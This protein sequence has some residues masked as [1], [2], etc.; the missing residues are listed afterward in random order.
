[1]T[2]HYDISI[3]S[4]AY[5]RLRVFIIHCTVMF[6]LACSV[7][8]RIHPPRFRHPTHWCRVFQS[9]D[10]HPCILTVPR[11]SFSRFQSPLLKI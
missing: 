7:S 9:R 3:S 1:M 2:G 8:H 10:F 4:A 11:Y 5:L 6:V